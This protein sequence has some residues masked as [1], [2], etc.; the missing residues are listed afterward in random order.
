MTKPAAHNDI[1]QIQ[2]AIEEVYRQ[3][4]K[5][6]NHYHNRYDSDLFRAMGRLDQ[7]MLNFYE[8]YPAIEPDT[9]LEP[10]SDFEP[11]FEGERTLQLVSLGG[12]V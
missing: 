7:A 3:I 2:N 12:A 6:I 8:Q 1:T 9:D 10:N 4:E 5:G 11:D